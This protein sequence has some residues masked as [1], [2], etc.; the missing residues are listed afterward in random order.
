MNKEEDILS[1][2]EID[3]LLG[4]M[5]DDDKTEKMPGNRVLSQP[6]K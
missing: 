2:D 3:D 6:A 5:G 4:M 1:Q